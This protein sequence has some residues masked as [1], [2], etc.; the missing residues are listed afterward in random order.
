MILY[1]IINSDLLW[2]LILVFN[3][4][5]GSSGWLASFPPQR[6]IKLSFYLWTFIFDLV[7][8]SIVN[9]VLMT[10]AVFTNCFIQIGGIRGVRGGVRGSTGLVLAFFVPSCWHERA[11]LKGSGVRGQRPRRTPPDPS[12]LHG[13]WPTSSSAPP[14]ETRTSSRAGLRFNSLQHNYLICIKKYKH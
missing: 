1:I 3:I 8:C 2:F 12:H 7:S 5:G 4:W 10:E 14:C 13:C 9:P 6:S 11:E